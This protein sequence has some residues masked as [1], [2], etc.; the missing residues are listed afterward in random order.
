[1]SRRKGKGGEGDENKSVIPFVA[2]GMSIGMVLC[3]LQQLL[4]CDMYTGQL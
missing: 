2:V 1:M 4:I 3:L